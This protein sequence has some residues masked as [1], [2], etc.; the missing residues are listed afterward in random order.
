MPPAAALR[1]SGRGVSLWDA[2]D[3]VAGMPRSAAAAARVEE[4]QRRRRVSRASRAAARLD[5]LRKSKKSKGESDGIANDA[6]SALDDPQKCLADR[7]VPP[8]IRKAYGIEDEVSTA[9]SNAQAVVVNQGYKMADL[10]A[11]C[12]EYDLKHCP[13]TVTNVGK[14][15]GEAGDEAT[16]DVQYSIATGQGVPETWVYINGQTA[17]PFSDWITWASNTTDIPWVHSLSVGEPED[18]FASDNGGQGAVD[19]MNNELAAIGARGVSII[20]ASGDSGY[21]VAQKYPSS[22]PYVTS[23]GGVFNGELGDDVLQVDDETT[24]GFSSLAVNPIGKWQVDAV[25]AWEKTK[26]QRPKYNASRRACPDLSIYDAG[27]YTVQDGSDQPIGGTSAAAPT[28]AGMI[29]SINGHL[30]DA[31]K[32]TLGFL[33][34]FLYQHEGAFLD[35]VHGGNNGFDATVGYD[36]ASGLGT[37]S[38]T[39]FATLKAAALGK[40]KGGHTQDTFFPTP[41]SK[42]GVAADDTCCEPQQYKCCTSDTDCCTDWGQLQCS[43]GVCVFPGADK[44]HDEA[45]TTATARPALPTT[46]TLLVGLR[47]SP[48]A[49]QRLDDLFWAVA[50][51]AQPAFTQLSGPTDIAALSLADAA[52]LDAA[53]AWLEDIGADMRT[54]HVMPT[55]DA[56]EVAWPQGKGQTSAPKRPACADYVVLKGA[57]DNHLTSD[58]FKSSRAGAGASKNNNSNNDHPF[59]APER[60]RLDDAFGPTAQKKAYNV[61]ANLKGTHSGN[62]QMVFGTGTFGYREADIDL[63]FSTYATSSSTKDVSFDTSNKWTGKTGK[64]FVEGELDVSYIAAFAPGVKTLVANP[65]ISA[66]TESG[67]GFGAALLA[68]LVELNGRDTVP[69]VLS[70]SLG[71]LSFGSCDKMCTAL[72]SK[73]GHTYKA[74]WSYLQTQFQACMFDSEAVEQ[75]IDAELAKLG[76]RGTTVTAAS[77]DGAS[78]FAFGPF[79]GDI[80]SDLNG[81]ICG[82]M[83]MPVFPTA[84]PYVLSVGGTQWSSDDIYGPECSADKPCGWTDGGAG[85]AWKH[86]QPSFQNNVTAVYLKEARKVA[87]KTMVSAGTFNASGRGYPDVAALAQFG[88]PLCD[89]GGCSG[90]GGTSASAPTVAGMLSLINDA[91]LNAGLKSL[92]YVNTKLYALMA[93]PSVYAECFTDIGIK[94][95]G[96]E[97]DCQTYSSCD[98][99]DDGAGSG[100]GF[101]A[102]EGWDA[103][104]GFG[105]PNFAG[106]LKYLGKD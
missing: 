99:C 62:T 79:S 9:A 88:I 8:C 41:D 50:D 21:Q 103:Q 20:F 60:R 25:A 100:P 34:Y 4:E 93:D 31:G 28:L 71:S 3:T 57:T 32:P 36:P 24:G 55:G 64:N 89:Y 43:V 45:T 106:W 26:G 91:R 76:L 63:F 37:F 75:R 86:A 104:T 19:R 98:G 40:K 49:R 74:C 18:E 54:L 70:M 84:S 23:V 7:A 73:G 97:W 1:A 2:V 44:K 48:A 11:F 66:A 51:P 102:T 65:N 81:I 13:T 101:V 52:D 42:K 15:D 105:Q 87:P 83:N 78:H 92:G 58:L 33:N 14:N 85:F 94:K 80:G 68:F 16:L 72:A 22:S 46:P 61:P 59:A 6:A 69:Y 95:L 17:N 82:Q 10:K 5:A 90:S 35:I 29:S 53:K 30:L 39:T 12:S 47:H 96:D 67:E 77:G 38:P 27:F 56:I